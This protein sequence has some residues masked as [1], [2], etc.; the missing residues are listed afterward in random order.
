MQTKLFIRFGFNAIIFSSILLH[1]ASCE[2]DFSP[3]SEFQERYILNCIIRSDTAFQTFT[4]AKSYNV[5]GYD[6]YVQSKNPF[7]K[8][9]DARLWHKDDVYFFKD[10]MSYSQGVTRYDEPT[11]YYYTNEFIPSQGDSIKLR[12]IAPDNTTLWGRT[13][14]PDSVAWDVVNSTLLITDTLGANFSYAWI[15]KNYL[16][17]YLPRMSIYYRLAGDPANVR[18]SIEV[19]KKIEIQNGIETPVKQDPLRSTR[20]SVQKSAVDYAMRSISGSDPAKSSYIIYAAI[21]DLL[22]FDEPLSKY[23]SN[24]KGFLDDYTIRVDQTDFT[25]I[26][27]GFG[28]FGSYLKQQRGIRID[29]DY[30]TKFGYTAANP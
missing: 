4:I 8:V 28:I 18:R 5:E 7:I 9:L 20:F 15:S 11:P 6:P 24:S 2:E 23:F 12:I 21:I 14:L 13:K 16:S 3:R 27:G 30:I 26:E 17:W 25:N 29:T 10:S 19:P 1:L 22:V